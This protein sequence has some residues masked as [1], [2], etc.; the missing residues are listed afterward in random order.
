MPIVMSITLFVITQSPVSLVLAVLSPTVLG[1]NLLVARRGERKRFAAET[2]EFQVAVEQLHRQTDEVHAAERTQW[3]RKHPHAFVIGYAPGPSEAKVEGTASTPRLRALKD[4]VRENPALPVAIDMRHEASGARELSVA[5]TGVLARQ[6]KLKAEQHGIE[7]ILGQPKQEPSSATPVL[8]L[9]RDDGVIRLSTGERVALSIGATARNQTVVNL[10]D[11]SH[12]L[13]RTNHRSTLNAV[14]GV[15]SGEVPIMIDLVR[16]GPHALIAGTTGSGKSELLQTFIWQ[17]ALRY[18]TSRVQFLLLDFKGG[19]S[20]QYLTQLPHTLELLTDLEHEQVQRTVSGL[21]TE[22]RRRERILRE[23]GVNDISL[24]PESA[25]LPRLVIAVDE[26]AT[27]LLELPDLHAVFTDIGARGR[28]LGLHL[29]IATQ[30]PGGVVRD[31]LAANCTLRFCLRVANAQESHAV[32]GSDAAM[33]LDPNILGACMHQARGEVSLRWRVTKTH[34]DEISTLAAQMTDDRATRPWLPAL[35]KKV[36]VASWATLSQGSVY[37]GLCD[38]PEQQ[39][40]QPV[41]WNPQQHSPLLVLGCSQSG[42]T[43]TADLIAEQWIEQDQEHEVRFIPGSAEIVWQQLAEA[44]DRID[45]DAASSPPTLWIFDDL[46]AAIDQMSGDHSSHVGHLLNRVVRELPK[47]HGI[48]FTLAR[49][50]SQLSAA[51]LTTSHRVML[52]AAHKEQHVMWGLSSNTYS[53]KTPPG[54]A[55]YGDLTIQV[56]YAGSMVT[57]QQLAVEPLPAD[58][59]LA[60]VSSRTR[61]WQRHTSARWPEVECV[62]IGELESSS[63]VTEISGEQSSRPVYIGDVDEWL[64]NPSLANH[65]RLNATW[66]FD[67]CS[68]LELRQ[69]IR[70]STVPPPVIRSDAVVTWRHQEGFKTA[71]LA[72]HQEP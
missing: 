39:L 25:A 42:K 60:V 19:T 2:A 71:K 57:R 24:L 35:P 66:I 4:R 51:L 52:R 28:S 31:A 46:D 21:T 14:L 72:H 65:L 44:L 69:I 70:K 7:V 16:D 34:A 53:A 22:M 23:Q 8:Q 29:I 64:S 9:E 30:R 13:N 18:P 37:L 62:R 32:L 45:S 15:G 36:S 6:L 20:L 56:G 54:R 41:E 40:Q 59:L 61:F 11:D 58:E 1:M 49:L 3:L 27:L 68:A 50:P 10:G 55:H 33:R 43:N 17:L 5:F 63:R 47:Q 38:V 26:F 12:Q 48:V 67:G